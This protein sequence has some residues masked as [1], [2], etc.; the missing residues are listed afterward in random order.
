MDPVTSEWKFSLEFT[1][2]T[3]ITAAL[4]NVDISAT[5]STGG[6]TVRTGLEMRDI[7]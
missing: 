7:L 2:G 5:M 6:S 1:N 4:D 3:K